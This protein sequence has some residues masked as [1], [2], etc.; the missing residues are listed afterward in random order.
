MTVSVEP[1]NATGQPLLRQELAELVNA[2]VYDNTKLNL[3]FRRP[4]HTRSTVAEVDRQQL[5]RT[6]LGV[7]AATVSGPVSF[8]DLIMPTQPTSVPAVVG[9]AEVTELTHR[10]GSIVIV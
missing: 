1:A 5:I 7:G 9:W 2:G 3:G 8:A 6:A 10:I 4:R